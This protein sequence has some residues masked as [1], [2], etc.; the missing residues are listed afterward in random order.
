MLGDPVFL[1]TPRGVVPTARALELAGPIAEVLGG[2]R[3]VLATTAPFD[4]HSSSRAFTIGAPDTASAVFLLPLLERMR[5]E[6]PG[7]DVRLRQ[8]LP[9]GGTAGS[10]DPVFALLDSRALDVAIGP[11]EEIPARFTV[12]RL[13]EEVF[14]IV[15]RKGHRFARAPT[16]AAYC[17]ES[18]LVVS[19]SG[20]PRGFVDAALA[21]RGLRRRVALTVPSFHMALAVVAETDLLAAVPRTFAL[22]HARRMGLAVSEPP[23]PLPRSELAMVSPA[24]ALADSGLAWLRRSVLESIVPAPRARVPRSR[25]RR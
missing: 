20:D 17:A 2:A 11:F 3:K 24:A 18:H 25:T 22:A 4:P 15:A 13:R 19:L 10:R 5:R 14:A 23:L 8:L 6:A 1:R 21:G 16:L 7:V 9:P 12:E